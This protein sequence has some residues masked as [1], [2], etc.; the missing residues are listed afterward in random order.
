MRV[1]DRRLARVLLAGGLLLAVGGAAAAQREGRIAP[2][3]RLECPRDN[4]TSFTGRVVAYRRAAGRVFL[5]VR[6]DEQTTEEF[7]LRAADL[8][9]LFLLRGEAFRRGNWRRIETRPGRLRAGVRATVWACYVGDEPQAK[10][11]DW[12]PGQNREQ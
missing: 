3:A 11:I 12:S 7:T 1:G 9:R 10:L 8:R 6:T 5:R 2:P 4:T